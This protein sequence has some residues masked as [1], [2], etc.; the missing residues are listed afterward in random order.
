MLSPNY[1][2]WGK[3]EEKNLE[4]LQLEYASDQH[5]QVISIKHLIQT[6]SVNLRSTYFFSLF[7]FHHISIHHSLRVGIPFPSHS[8]E[9]GYKNRVFCD[10]PSTQGQQSRREQKH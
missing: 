4:F 10:Q 2:V 7:H 3:K 6:E 9:I 5:H 8:H 1:F